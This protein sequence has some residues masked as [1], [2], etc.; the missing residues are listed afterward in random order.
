MNDFVPR[1]HAGRRVPGGPA[2]RDRASSRRSR[3]R[4][5]PRPRRLDRAAPRLQIIN[6]YLG[7]IHH[8]DAARGA[9]SR[10]LRPA[11]ARQCL[12][13][14]LRRWVAALRRRTGP[15]AARAGADPP[16]RGRR[17]PVAAGHRWREPP[18]RWACAPGHWASSV[19]PRSWA[20]PS[21]RCSAPSSSR[22]SGFGTRSTRTGSGRTAHRHADA[23]LEVGVL[24]HRL[25]RA[26]AAVY[27]WA[28]SADWMLPGSRSLDVIGAVLFSVALAAGLLALTLIGDETGSALTVTAAALVIAV[29]SGALAILRMTRSEAPFLDLRL[30]RDRVFG[31]AV[32]VSILTGYAPRPH[33]RHGRVRGPRPVRR[34][35][36]A[37]YGAG[38]AGPRDGARAAVSGFAMRRFGA[39]AVTMAGLAAL[40]RG[41]RGARQADRRCERRV[42]GGHPGVSGLGFGR[43]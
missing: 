36:C 37:A 21:G 6:A 23:E 11:Q 18:V 33:R 5:P 4:D 43:P 9:G 26:S 41:A 39:T 8:G 12:A 30:F 28:A 42:L 14:R 1:A 34:A 40:D 32:L 38:R 15:R 31:S 20:W 2:R 10:P 35:R 16:G 27:V 24:R 25:A 3:R 29:V 17:G 7:R 13:P 19:P 22:G